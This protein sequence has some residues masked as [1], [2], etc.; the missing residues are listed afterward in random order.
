MALGAGVLLGGAV[1]ALYVATAAKPTT[2]TGPVAAPIAM[3]SPA[4]P[5]VSGDLPVTPSE[6]AG[7][8]SPALLAPVDSSA[9]I[10]AA[11]HVRV[12]RPVVPRGPAR[13]HSPTQAPGAPSDIFK[14]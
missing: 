5:S 2:T 14:P 9:A 11:P 4:S 7:V 12:P 6:D 3:S 8:A 13:N 1:I 10:P